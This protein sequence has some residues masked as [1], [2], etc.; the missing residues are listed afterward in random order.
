MDSRKFPVT[1]LFSM[2]AAVLISG[3][4]STTVNINQPMLPVLKQFEHAPA[5]GPNEADMPV[6]RLPT[7][8]VAM[9]W[10]GR[11]LAQHPFLFYGEGNNVL[12]VVNHGKVIW[13]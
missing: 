12:Y 8:S 4:A 3:C 13:A 10:P 5:K 6:R 7:N 11:G 2:L 9:N 1:G